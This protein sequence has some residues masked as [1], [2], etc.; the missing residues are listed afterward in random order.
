MSVVIPAY[1]AQRSLGRVLAALAAQQPPPEEVI[2]VDN[3][4]TDRT[5]E[6][7]AAHGA[8]V[9]TAPVRSAGGARNAGW[10]AARSEI[11]V[12]LDSDAIPQA[13]WAEGLQRA[14][15]EFPG[16]IVG[17]AHTFEPRTAWDWSRTFR[18]KTPY[19][20]FGSPRRTGSVSSY[21]HGRTA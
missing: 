11:V 10:D 16:A 3:D 2:V 8:R 7:A 19:L 4:S 14:L 6:I 20:P 1:N 5:S 18:S 21:L 15:D 12:F 13:G 9:V 17:F